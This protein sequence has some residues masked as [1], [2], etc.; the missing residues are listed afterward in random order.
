MGCDICGIGGF[1][2]SQRSFPFKTAKLLW[3]K[4]SEG[5]QEGDEQCI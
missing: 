3:I 4:Y 1:G 2:G 5:R